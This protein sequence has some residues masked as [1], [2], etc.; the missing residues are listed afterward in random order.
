MTVLLLSCQQELAWQQGAASGEWHTLVQHTALQPPCQ[1]PALPLPPHNP[2]D[3][4]TGCQRQ[5]AQINE[6]CRV[7]NGL[8]ALPA[9]AEKHRAP[10]STPVLTH[11]SDSHHVPLAIWPVQHVED[12]LQQLSLKD[13]P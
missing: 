10:H 13:A 6:L 8:P 9:G 11:S 7:L 1:A 5:R 3:E 4:A 12:C 2:S